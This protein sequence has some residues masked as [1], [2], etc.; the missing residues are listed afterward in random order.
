MQKK[1]NDELVKFQLDKE[2]DISVAYQ[3]YLN[4]Y[5]VDTTKRKEFC[6]GNLYFDTATYSK[7]ELDSFSVLSSKDSIFPFGNEFVRFNK[8]KCTDLS[9]LTFK[10]LSDVLIKDIHCKWTYNIDNFTNYLKSVNYTKY[11]VHKNYGHSIDIESSYGDRENSVEN[12]ETKIESVKPF[13]FDDVKYIPIPLQLVRIMIISTDLYF[14][15]NFNKSNLPVFFLEVSFKDKTQKSFFVK[16]NISF[17]YV[18]YSIY[19][20]KIKSIAGILNIR[21]IFA[22]IGGAIRVIAVSPLL[23]NL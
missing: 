11:K 9:Y 3:K 16:Y 13:N 10:N 15:S 4:L 6:F 8:E 21:R 22:L 1:I 5:I 19:D 2:V 12:M 14:S 18:G 20:S 23:V 17:D 7:K